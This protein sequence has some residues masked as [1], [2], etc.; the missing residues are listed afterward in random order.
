MWSLALTLLFAGSVHRSCGLVVQGT[1]FSLS[2]RDQPT[3]AT[4]EAVSNLNLSGTYVTNITVNGRQFRV[5]IDTG[6][7]DLWIVPP[8][9][10]SFNDTGV[11]VDDGYL[12][13]DVNGTIGVA[14]VGLGGYT[15]GSQAFN[16]ATT[17]QLGGIVDIGLDGLIGLSF[18]SKGTS[19]ISDALVAEGMDPNLGKP[20]LFNIFD[21]TPNK[22]NFIGISLSRTDDLEGSAAASFTINE[23][24]PSYAAAANA[25]SVPLFPGDNGVWSVLLDGISVDGVNV[26]LPLSNVFKAPAGKNVVVLDTGTPTA[27]LPQQ[28]VDAIYT[29]IP[30][31]KTVEDESGE[32]IWTVPCNTTTSVSIQIGGQSFPIHPLDISDVVIDTLHNTPVCITPWSGAEGGVDFDILFGDSFMRNFYSLFNFGDAV[33]TAPTGNASSIQ[34]L[35]QTDAAAAAKD[36]ITVR[37]ALLSGLTNDAQGKD[38]KKTSA[39]PNLKVAPMAVG[40]LFAGFIS[41]VIQSF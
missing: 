1:P 33:S 25:P 5:A 16:N 34:L 4:L 18:D 15:F 40:L 22:N 37:M 41:V 2:A 21:Q 23:M 30:G 20:F 12:G 28:L 13:G 3:G 35:S 9:D 17:F 36:V 14:S 32:L 27:Q 10:F 29:K 39:T 24:D 26:P 38:G 19:P 11:F 6:S 8:K 7:S 31:A